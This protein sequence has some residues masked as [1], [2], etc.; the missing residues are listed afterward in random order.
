MRD[1]QPVLGDTHGLELVAYLEGVVRVLGGAIH[2]PLTHGGAAAQG[3]RLELTDVVFHPSSGVGVVAQS[4]GSAWLDGVSILGRTAGALAALGEGSRVE[5]RGLLLRD[6][7]RR[8]DLK[9]GF[10][11]ACGD[12][13]S[14]SLEDVLVG[15]S[16]ALGLVAEGGSL[17][18][19]RC[20]VDQ[21]LLAGVFVAD[22]G[23]ALLV[24][25]TVSGVLPEATQQ[26]GV[27]VFVGAAE[28]RPVPRLTATGLE[29][30][31]TGIAG[32]WAE[33]GDLTLAG[34]SLSPEGRV[35]V[36]PG[37]WAHGDGLYATRSV[38]HLS[39]CH[40][41]DAPGVGLFLNGAEGLESDLSYADNGEDRVEA[42]D[43]PTL[44]L[45]FW[46]QVD[47][48]GVL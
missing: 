21:A 16:E 39:D 41:H 11:A 46:N 44:S 3:G 32:V 38:V 1:T 13:G 34:C 47:L 7:R 9:V 12:G 14:M 36:L 23:T 45:D 20:T 22:G 37:V 25:A 27:G 4:Q 10:G 43:R 40:L 17:S 28:G 35:E 18:C 5:G 19:T 29:V 15:S 8:D 42:T 2:S 31:A 26:V 24:D 48:G 33:G 30:E 6:T